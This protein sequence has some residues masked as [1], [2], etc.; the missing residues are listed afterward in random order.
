MT[1][2]TYKAGTTLA[3]FMEQL[4]DEEPQLGK[5]IKDSDISSDNFEVKWMVG[6]YSEPWQLLRKQSHGRIYKTWKDKIPSNAVLFP[7]KLSSNGR[8][9]TSLIVKLKQEYELKCNGEQ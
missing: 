1:A 5:L 2:T 8:L 9:S 6:T 4:A 7:I 3:C